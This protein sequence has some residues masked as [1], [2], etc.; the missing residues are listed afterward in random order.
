MTENMI[1]KKQRDDN[2]SSEERTITFSQDN[3][4][5]TFS[6]EEDFSWMLKDRLYAAGSEGNGGGGGGGCGDGGV[7]VG[8]GGGRGG[9]GRGRGGNSGDGKI[10]C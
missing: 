5:N 4:G 1:R 10:Y 2:K 3:Q 7:R 8:D 6:G 9:G